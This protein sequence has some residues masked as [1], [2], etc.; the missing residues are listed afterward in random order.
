MRKNVA[1]LT[2]G[3]S[4]SSV[5]TA[6]I[7]KAGYWL[8]DS[9]FKRYDYET[10]ENN[11][12]VDLNRMIC[13][14]AGYWGNHHR[15]FSV[16]AIQKVAGLYGTLTG[17]P[18]NPLLSRC[19]EFVEK[20][21]DHQPWIWKDPRLWLTLYFW[22][23]L[24]DWRECQFILLTRDYK[25]GWTGELLRRAVWSY[26]AF[27]EYQE[28]VKGVMLDFL[29]ANQ[30]SFF[31]LKYE[32]LIMRPAE[33]ICSLNSY[34]NI[35]LTV[36]DLRKVYAKPLYK[37]PRSSWDFSIAVLIY[38]KNYSERIRQIEPKG[39]GRSQRSELNLPDETHCR[40]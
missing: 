38:L 13:Q 32:D 16:E 7:S 29:A 5:L 33:S 11:E 30:L 40:Q 31:H 23:F 19:A 15:E 1:I 25:Q 22:Q 17:Y 8:G 35:N 37:A 20:C 18:D 39:T 21:K 3:L 24:V 27:K 28:S 12:L 36:N 4:G 6:L 9:T 34:L 10:F 14:E 2:T 26:R